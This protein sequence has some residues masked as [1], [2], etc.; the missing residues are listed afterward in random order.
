MIIGES[1]D[2]TL[3]INV[4]VSVLTTELFGGHVPHLETWDRVLGVE[5]FTYVLDKVIVKDQIVDADLGCNLSAC[6]DGSCEW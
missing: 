3:A 6:S 4:I 5:L 2:A 1:K